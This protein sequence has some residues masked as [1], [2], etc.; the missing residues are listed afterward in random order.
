MCTMCYKCAVFIG[1]TACEKSG[2]SEN[3]RHKRMF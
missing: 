2:I 1:T 3:E